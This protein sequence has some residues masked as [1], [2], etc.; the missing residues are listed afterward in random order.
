MAV[1]E[2]FYEI[3]LIWK[4]IAGA[5]EFTCAFGAADLSVSPRTATEM[6]NDA[7]IAAVTTG[8]PCDN[9]SM[10]DDY[11]FLGVSVALGTSTGDIVGQHLETLAGSISDA[12]P[13]VNCSLLVNKATALG[14]RRYRGR[15]F[16]PPC[17]VNEGAVDSIGTISGSTL[18]S[19]ISQW[20]SFYDDLVADNIIP[21]LFHQGGGAPVPTPITAFTVQALM[22]TQRRRMRS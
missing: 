9:A 16:V 22:A 20:S 14:G 10:M 3:T 5:R 17:G 19:N 13:P 7:Y 18:T 15:M 11:S 6:A 2:D 21:H 4:A 12:C 8:N 1:P